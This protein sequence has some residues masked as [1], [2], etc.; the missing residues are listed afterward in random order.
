MSLT[1]WAMPCEPQGRTDEAV[2]AYREA[3]RLKPDHAE[4]HCNLAKQLQIQGKYGESL[5]AYE[6]AQ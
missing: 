5:A 4:A 6:R 2:A 3:I 1:P